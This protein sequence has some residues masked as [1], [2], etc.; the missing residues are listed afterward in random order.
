MIIIHAV[1][2]FQRTLPRLMEP[3]LRAALRRFPIVVLTGARQ[4]GKSTLVTRSSVGA[5]RTY[6]SMDDFDVLDRARRQPDSLLQDAARI[7]LDEV[8]RV[9]DL[10]LAIK[11][12]VDKDRR[13]GRFLLTGS[14]TS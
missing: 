5:G 11:R 6:R 3:V 14:P 12:S 13:G 2:R 8:Q 7:T 1:N 10:L 9:P 4:T